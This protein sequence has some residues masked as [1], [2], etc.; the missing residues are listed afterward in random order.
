MLFDNKRTYKF[1]H[2]CETGLIRDHVDLKRKIE[3][4]GFP[5][6]RLLT[7]RDRQWT[8][9]ELNNYFESRPA[10]ADGFKSASKPV[11]IPKPKT[12]AKRKRAA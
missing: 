11:V 2:I 9:A 5:R 12:K 7:R 3:Q 4:F 10:T 1:K 6:G 8:G